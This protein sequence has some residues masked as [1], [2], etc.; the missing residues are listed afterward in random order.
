MTLR[1]IVEGLDSEKLE[2]SLAEALPLRNPSPTLDLLNTRRAA[3]KSFKG[4]LLDGGVPVAVQLDPGPKQRG[5]FS[6]R[7][8][9][10]TRYS[11]GSREFGRTIFTNEHKVAFD[12]QKAAS[13]G[14]DGGTRQIEAYPLVEA[15]RSVEIGQ[16][17]EV[18]VGLV[19]E[20][21]P[22]V[23]GAKLRIERPNNEESFR[24]DVQ[25]V[26]EGFEAPAG[27]RH[28]I[29]VITEDPFANSVRVPLRA[30][31]LPGDRPVLPTALVVIFMLDGAVVGHASRNITVRPAAARAPAPTEK[32]SAA[33][34]G[35]IVLDGS[36][37]PADLEI[38]ISKPDRNPASGRYQITFCS[39]H[40][41][42]LPAEPLLL[43]LGSDAASF[44]KG[45]V[46]NIAA[47][48]GSKLQE[49]A[50]RGQSKTIADQLPK[51]FWEPLRAVSNQLAGRMPSVLIVSVDPFIPWELTA[52][53]S[54]LD[55]KLPSYLGVQTRLGRWLMSPNGK[56][57]PPKAS[58]QVKAMATMIGRYEGRDR[59]PMAEQ[60]GA[61]LRERYKAIAVSATEE[62]LLQLLDAKLELPTGEEVGGVEAIHVAAHGESDPTVPG[63]AALFLSDG[64]P[65]SP[66]VFRDASIGTSHEPFL[67]LNACMVGTSGE[68][69]GG[70]GGYPNACL[71]A[72]F[73]GLLGPLW[74]V[75]DGVAH[76]IALEFY[77]RAF[78]S[79]D[80]PPEQIGSI[81]ADLRLRASGARPEE[82]QPTFLAYAYY[83]H[84]EL[85]LQS[86]WST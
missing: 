48:P 44:A 7:G 46:D 26:A 38:V 77:R 25:L 58:V 21:D 84:P 20:A 27:W 19:T 4:L 71:L 15:P 8:V 39:R 73:R 62:D 60:E 55:P 31:P 35:P 76:D 36:A 63:S 28:S 29:T 80:T 59:L 43:E 14:S 54:P 86:A 72:G 82:F 51:G 49:R 50:L 2:L 78:G 16:E 68:L 34:T 18:T 45:I 79:A 83:G 24:L 17:F 64:E 67:F 52:M 74:V 65:L 30:L 75:D 22:A 12:R 32:A 66:F 70:T 9:Q 41:I 61:T 1:E 23:T 13:G 42:A 53:E 10:K 57:R 37:V 81:L 47:K 6:F 40:P 85:V 33:E 3:A 69:L 11:R 5:N 56:P